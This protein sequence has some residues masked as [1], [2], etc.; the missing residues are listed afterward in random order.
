MGKHSSTQVSG[1]GV[2]AIIFCAHPKSGSIL[3]RVC[4]K[5]F[6]AALLAFVLADAVQAQGFGTP[7]LAVNTFG[8]DAGSWRVERHPRL[9]G[10]VNGD[11]RAD[12]VGF[13]S[14]V[15]PPLLGPV[16]TEKS[17]LIRLK[18]A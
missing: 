18:V 8:Y 15:P 16:L 10:D 14:A 3:K 11:R 12:I 9:L 1:E 4:F 7:R 13:G 5:A 17:S 6:L 2:K